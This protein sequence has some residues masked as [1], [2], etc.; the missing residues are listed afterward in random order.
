MRGDSSW[1][2]HICA[3]RHP[4][5]SEDKFMNNAPIAVFEP[6]AIDRYW[7]VAQV[8][9]AHH[10]PARR[11]RDLPAVQVDCDVRLTFRAP[12][13]DVPDG[14]KES[15]RYTDETDDNAT[16]GYEPITHVVES[17]SA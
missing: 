4:C 5:A 11:R 1:N 15:D 14:R 8:P 10:K 13:V 3:S 2:R 16:P 7:M 9:R 12:R 6:N 17:R